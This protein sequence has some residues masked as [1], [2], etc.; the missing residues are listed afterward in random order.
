MQ[1]EKHSFSRL[2]AR[3]KVVLPDPERPR[4]T[5][6]SPARMLKVRFFSEKSGMLV[7]Y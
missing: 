3:R 7:K 4:M 5:V 1:R 2:K 6:I